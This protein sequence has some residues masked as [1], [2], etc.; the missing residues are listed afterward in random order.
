MNYRELI[1]RAG[2]EV[3]GKG[4]AMAR[5]YGVRPPYLNLFFI[6]IF[7]FL[8]KNFLALLA[9]VYCNQSSYFVKDPFLNL[10]IA[11]ETLPAKT[12][13]PFPTAYAAV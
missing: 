9:I 4:Q 8:K 7:F 5:E 11:S 12:Y 3:V 6:Y 1:V 10:T 13:P 2:G